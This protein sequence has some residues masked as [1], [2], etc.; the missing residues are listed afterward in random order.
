MVLIKE[1]KKLLY[2]YVTVTF[3]KARQKSSHRVFLEELPQWERCQIS[4]LANFRNEKEV[5][6]ACYY[7][8][9]YKKKSG[10]KC[11]SAA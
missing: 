9:G 7:L 1:R 10:R 11:C 8:I 5:A 4:C 3:T 2:C 6:V